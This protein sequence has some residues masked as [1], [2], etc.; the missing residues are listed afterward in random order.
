MLKT[1]ALQH[2]RAHETYG[3]KQSFICANTS[4]NQQLGDVRLTSGSC[5]H[6]PQGTVHSGS[7]RC[8]GRERARRLPLQSPKP[9]PP[10]ELS[11]RS[12]PATLVADAGRRCSWL[13]RCL[14]KAPKPR[15]EDRGSRPR[16]Q[17]LRGAPRRSPRLSA[18]LGG[19]CTWRWPPR[20]AST[21]PGVSEVETQQRMTRTPASVPGKATCVR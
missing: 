5:H 17:G 10:R 8:R 2:I 11:A 4:V 13:A 14:R 20:H 21:P 3:Q 15:P 9:L 7:V 6:F 19:P 1:A 18:V 12:G 16:A